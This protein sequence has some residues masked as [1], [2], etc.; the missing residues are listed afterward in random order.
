MI[1]T[2]TCADMIE[3]LI[4]DKY[5]EKYNLD[6]EYKVTVNGADFTAYHDIT[7]EF[8]CL[9]VY[10]SVLPAIVLCHDENT[11]CLFQYNKL[12]IDSAIVSSLIKYICALNTN[13][14]SDKLYDIERMLRTD[15]KYFDRLKVDYDD[16]DER[17]V[18]ETLEDNRKF[19]DDAQLKH[20]IR[21]RIE[22]LEQD[23]LIDR[24]KCI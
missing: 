22:K 5:C 13:V 12:S 10:E 2:E 11:A 20:R 19:F 17:L 6:Y 21:L 9:Y 23:N 16:F 18:T 8:N 4:V 3:R 15:L 1:Y 14:L 24:I 7:K